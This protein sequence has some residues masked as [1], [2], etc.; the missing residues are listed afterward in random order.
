MQR[1][2]TLRGLALLLLL[3]A[4]AQA[5]SSGIQGVVRDSSEAVIPA[6]EM[7]V[8]NL[9]TGVKHTTQTNDVGFFSIPFLNPGNY[10]I[11]AVGEGFAP[12]VRENLKLDVQQI[13]RV[14]FT[15]AIGTVAQTVEVSAA[16]ALL[17]S[18]Q[19]TMGQVIDNKRIVEMPLNKRNYLELARLSVG[20][21]PG[22]NVGAGT[23]PG[24]N[25][26]GYVGMG[27]R[28]YQNEVL[29]DGV[30]NSSRS[31]GG[32]LG[33]E[34]QAT[35]PSVDAVGEFKVVT[36]NFSAEYGY[37]M[38]PKVLVSIKSG[39][40]Q[41][42]GSLFEF[43]RNDKLD[44]ANFF[45]NRSGSAKPT[46][47]QNQFGG[48]IG[49]PIVKNKTFGFFSY[50]GTRIRIGSSLFAN[51]PSALARS[52]DFSQER[53]N[54]NKVYDPASTSGTGAA[55]IR[56]RFPND[57]IPS[58][59][60]DP[61][62]VPLLALYPR[63]NVQGQEF[64]F[65][66]YFRSP[67]N[68]DDTDL[69]DF[70]VDHN[71]SDKDRVFFRMSIRDQF[72]VTESP[73]PVEAGGQG[74]ETVNLDGNNLG[75]TWTHSFGATVHNEMR[76][77]FTHFPSRFDTLIQEP[78]N[79]KYGIKNSPG[80]GFDDG[81]NQ[82]FSAFNI[83]GYSTLGTPCCWP[84]INNMDNVHFSNNL[85]WQRG[86][87]SIKM[88]FDSRRLNIYREAMRFRRG[89]F[90]FTKVFTAERPNN[91]ASRNTT[92]NGLA[93]MMLGW[94]Q[95]TQ[96]GNPAGENAVVPYY[97]TYIQDDWRA[98]SKL[99]VTMGLRWELFHRGFYPNGTIRDAPAS[100]TTSRR[101]TVCSRAKRSTSRG[102]PAPRTA[103]ATRT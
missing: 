57:V 103:A 68:S 35:K 37:R 86:N 77:G 50:Q 15:L 54:I 95:S 19:A 78:L 28:G 74:G 72:R 18:E 6:V 61:V 26:A 45:A 63:S 46:L 44:A 10:R 5:Q 32:P 88:G 29:I 16:A 92:G 20:I 60:F 79:A 24:Q 53:L 100:A 99:T 96:V 17:E 89:Q 30:D 14:N 70:R 34:A 84:N 58:S 65:N 83:N 64:G 62:S 101:S 13:A 11:E 94:V 75:F 7:T 66:N 59:R 42:H 47:R 3:S 98:T 73:L 49:G 23:R 22:N 56:Q 27:M 87:H 81:L 12:S 41:L 71:F 69:Y 55:A 8:T 91:A 82:G 1:F 51:V 9:G 85:M 31:G 102:R 25:E 80:D 4:A 33:F 36:N 21:L 67:S 48:T 76:F 97:G 40:N 90:N 93:D 2:L 52:G 39:T 38:G 43:I